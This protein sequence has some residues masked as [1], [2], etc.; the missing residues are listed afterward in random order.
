MESHEV[1]A[2]LVVLLQSIMTVKSNTPF[3]R[4]EQ[5]KSKASKSVATCKLLEIVILS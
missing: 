1:V 5:R 3:L 2:V 4:G